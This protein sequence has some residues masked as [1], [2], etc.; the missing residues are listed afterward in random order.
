MTEK[1]GRDEEPRPSDGYDSTGALRLL[2]ADF[3]P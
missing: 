3:V 2:A 1:K